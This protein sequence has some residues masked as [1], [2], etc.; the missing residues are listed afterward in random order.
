MDLEGGAHQ[1]FDC[2]IKREHNITVQTDPVACF[3]KFPCIL[4]IKPNW[5]EKEDEEEE[6]EWFAE[7]LREKKTKESS[8]SQGDTLDPPVWSSS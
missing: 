5:E 2:E 3:F 6:R 1:E 7:R 8:L 4:S